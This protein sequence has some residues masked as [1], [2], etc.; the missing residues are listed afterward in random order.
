MEFKLTDDIKKRLKAGES[1]TVADVELLLCLRFT[2]KLSK[3]QGLAYGLATYVDV[4]DCL[5][6]IYIDGVVINHSSNLQVEVNKYLSSIK[7]AFATAA[8]LM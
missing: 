5:D 4:G 1:I 6:N 3:I 8:H 2:I 7:D